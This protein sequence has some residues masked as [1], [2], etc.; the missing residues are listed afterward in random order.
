ML[1]TL[2]V[3]GAL[4][5]ISL[6]RPTPMT[7]TLSGATL[8]TPWWKCPPLLLVSRSNS[9][10]AAVEQAKQREVVFSSYDPPRPKRPPNLGFET[11]T[12]TLFDDQDFLSLSLSARFGLDMTHS[13]DD[14]MGSFDSPPPSPRGSSS[15]DDDDFGTPPPSPRHHAAVEALQHAQALLEALQHPPLW[16]MVDTPPSNPAGPGLVEAAPGGLSGPMGPEEE[17][18]EPPPKRRRLNRRF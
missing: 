8:V 13:H 16:L 5:E 6:Y 1:R 15:G 14:S 18:A 7:R 3:S 11:T 4:R 2:S 17:A 9:S 12:T 10:V